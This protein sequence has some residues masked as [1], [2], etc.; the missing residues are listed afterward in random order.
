VVQGSTRYPWQEK[1]LK[2][3]QRLLPALRLDMV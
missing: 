2:N 1:S 3:L